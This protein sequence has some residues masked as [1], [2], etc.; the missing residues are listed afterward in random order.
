MLPAIDKTCHTSRKGKTYQKTKTKKIK[1]RIKRK[2]HKKNSGFSS[3]KN[4][5]QYSDVSSEELSSSEAG[6]IHS[7]FDESNGVLSLKSSFNKIITDQL[8]IT[9][10]TS[11]R[12]LL[13]ACSPLSNQWELNSV[14]EDSSMSTNLSINNFIDMTSEVAQMKYKKSKKNK[15]PKSLTPKKKKKKKELK[16]K[17]D[18]SP[19]CD[20]SFKF[21]NLSNVEVSKHNGDLDGY[22]ANYKPYIEESHTPPLEN[23]PHIKVSNIEMLHKHDEKP[24]RRL[25]KEEKR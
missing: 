15:K 8:R 3:N 12:D 14:P 4:F 7:D 18:L 21:S 19:N 24:I 22:T 6:E 10:V 25:K 17:H 1:N 16:Y 23:S 9:R 11:P 2:S 13:E 20:S 5:V